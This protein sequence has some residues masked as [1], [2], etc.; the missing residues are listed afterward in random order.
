MLP[1]AL[2]QALLRQA[3]EFEQNLLGAEVIESSTNKKEEICKVC[4]IHQNASGEIRESSVMPALTTNSN[5]SGRNAPLIMQETVCI[6]I[7]DKATRFQNG[8]STRKNDGAGNGLGI[9]KESDPAPTLTAGDRHAVCL[10]ERD[11]IA[12][13]LTQDPVW[14]VEK[15]PC[16]SAGNSHNGQAVIGVLQTVQEKE[17]T[18]NGKTAHSAA[19][20]YRFD[21]LGSNS[22]RSSNPYSGCRAVEIAQTLDTSYPD[23]SKN[24][25]GIAI[26]C[27]SPIADDDT[28]KSNIKNLTPGESQ[29]S[30]IYD[31]SGVFPT[32]CAHENRGLDRQAVL[33]MAHSMP[34]AEICKD[35][36]P[37][38]TCH[39]EQP[40][41]HFA[42]VVRRLTPLECERLQGYPDG[43][44]DIGAW[45]DNKGKVH[46][47]SDSARY[48]ALGNSIALPP[49]RWVLRRVSA[50][51]G[52]HPTMAS[53]FDGIGGFPLL[54][55]QINGKGSCL[56]ASEIEE[57]PIAVTKAQIG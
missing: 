6:P 37:T 20:A 46:K 50:Y 14:K 31:S 26:L 40:L 28:T 12:F 27:T 52:E 3:G 55:E 32:L 44:T 33:C 9:G 10:Y 22:M 17:G 11:A 38:L 57:F 54:W 15:T 4:A 8:G 5:A 45:T 35:L 24:Q 48:K 30:R 29:S 56:W 42:A 21:G 7:N 41:I 49:W 39:H 1:E 23:P 47:T 13:H 51:C 43:W 16:L 34:H 25:G 53:L 2:K 18:D 36:A 19:Q